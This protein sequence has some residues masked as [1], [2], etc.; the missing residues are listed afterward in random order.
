MVLRMDKW[1]S[2]NSD[3]T[4]LQL[5]YP[6]TLGVDLVPVWSSYDHVEISDHGLYSVHVNLAMKSIPFLSV[7]YYWLIHK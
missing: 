6:F 5:H 7:A 3:Y 4:P 1:S 2:N